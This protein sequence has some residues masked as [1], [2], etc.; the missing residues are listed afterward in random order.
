MNPAESPS[1][2]AVAAALNASSQPAEAAEAHGSLC[3]LLSA[4]GPLAR[5]P[6]LADVLDDET[7]PAADAA[8]LE[9]LAD[10][11]WRDLDSSE[12]H[13]CPL[14]PD[15]DESL[16]L[17]SECLARW[18][19]G[20]TRGL[21]LARANDAVGESLDSPV[22][23][24]VVGDL[25]AIAGLGIDDDAGDDLEGDYMELVEYLR[26]SVQLVF[27]ELA[28]VRDLVVERTMH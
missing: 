26:V 24:E 17:R 5:E 3:G 9:A 8:I 18:C 6:W 14:L 20:Y 21:T 4:M 11:T 13:F 12:L 22:V 23:A 25:G 28:P 7:P 2:F 19:Q 15:D 10:S 16:E 1:F 27:E